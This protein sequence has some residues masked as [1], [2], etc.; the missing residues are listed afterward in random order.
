[1]DQTEV[2]KE[3]IYQT[4][5]VK[6]IIAPIESKTRKNDNNNTSNRFELHPGKTDINQISILNGRVQGWFLC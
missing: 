5:N 1:M 4:S 3:P 2:K 6:D